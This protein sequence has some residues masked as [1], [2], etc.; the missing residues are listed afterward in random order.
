MHSL[1]LCFCNV[2][3]AE[4]KHNMFRLIVL[5]HEW[6]FFRHLSRGGGVQF[7]EIP[8]K[9][10]GEGQICLWGR[11]MTLV[12]PGCMEPWKYSQGYNGSFRLFNFKLVSNL[13]TA[14]YIS[15][16]NQ[17]RAKLLAF[18]Q[19][20]KADQRQ[21][22]RKTAFQGSLEER[23]EGVTLSSQIFS[24]LIVLYNDFVFIYDM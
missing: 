14:F 1:F 2:L 11:G 16:R 7:R 6:V 9:C 19:P 18:E 17:W 23:S 8:L 15:D 24:A 10:M 12:A 5:G 4:L 13:L 21:T 20:D 22:M 3:T